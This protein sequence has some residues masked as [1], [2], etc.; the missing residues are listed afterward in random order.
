MGAHSVSRQGAIDHAVCELVERDA[1]AHMLPDGFTFEAARAYLV[2]S[3]QFVIDLRANGFMGFLFDVTPKGARLQTAAALIFDVD[4]GPVPLTAGYACRRSFDDAATAAA[5]EALQSR[6]TEIHGAREDVA[7]GQREAGEAF[8]E[9]L[10][11]CR[12]R[13]MPH[14]NYRGLLANAVPHEVWIATLGSNPWIV[15][16]VCPAMRVSHLL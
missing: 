1:V 3:P 11:S 8:R 7:I 4:G 15:K 10:T 9:F 5:L 2:E 16:A 12:P 14:R 6:L 13:S